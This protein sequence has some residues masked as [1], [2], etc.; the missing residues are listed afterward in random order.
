[1]SIKDANDAFQSARRMLAAARAHLNEPPNPE[2]N[3][4][5][6]TLAVLSDRLGSALQREDLAA[7]DSAARALG[8]HALSIQNLTLA[9]RARKSK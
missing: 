2:F 5:R 3:Q 1:M 8:A 6:Q 7:I 9:R 4:A